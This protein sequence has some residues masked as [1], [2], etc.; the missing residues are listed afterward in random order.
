NHPH[1]CTI[2]DTGECA[3]RPCLTREL[4]EGRTL[5]ELAS[6][7]PPLEGLP[8]VV[9]QAARALAAAHA[10]GV[11]H[12]DIGAANVMVRDDGSVKVLDFGLARRL[13]TFAAQGSPPSGAA[14]APE[15]RVGTV[16]YMSPEQA[17]AEPV[18][19]ASDIFALGIVLYELATGRHPFLAASEIG[20]LHAIVAQE[21]VPAA[22]VNPEV[23]ATL[24]ALIQR[25]LAKEARL[26]PTATE[27]DAVLTELAETKSG[28]P[29]PR[30]GTQARPTVGR[31]AELAALRA[32][33]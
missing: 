26:R 12:R 10:A 18:G 31:E 27:V 6:R 33:F 23:P 13:P 16:L 25:M 32:G 14:T 15:I 7:P 21:P 2:Y 28:P 9:R 29:A 4:I 1:I 3:G 11:V 20:V 17:R 30:S 5:K 8:R 19:T 24:E 22:R